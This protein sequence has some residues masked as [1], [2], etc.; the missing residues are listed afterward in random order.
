LDGKDGNRLRNYE[1]QKLSYSFSH[2]FDI[3][4]REVP[5]CWILRGQIQEQQG[6]P[7]LPSVIDGF[8][9]PY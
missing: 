5:G 9:D 3:S 1:N 4:K 8:G 6:S 7:A 2:I